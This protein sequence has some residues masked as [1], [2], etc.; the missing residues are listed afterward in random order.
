M[1]HGPKEPLRPLTEAERR[2]LERLR[3]AS[4]DRMDR[5]RRAIRLRRTGSCG[6][7]ALGSGGAPSRV[8]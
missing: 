6:G 1:A 8:P 2:A 4:S 3:R 5:V 7:T